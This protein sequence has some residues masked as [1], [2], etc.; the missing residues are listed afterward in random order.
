MIPGP[1]VERTEVQEGTFLSKNS[2]IM[3][4]LTCRITAYSIHFDFFMLPIV[5]YSQEDPTQSTSIYTIY[6]FSYYFNRG[7]IAIPILKAL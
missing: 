1:P 6:D 4:I 5:S 2:F 3:L 7:S